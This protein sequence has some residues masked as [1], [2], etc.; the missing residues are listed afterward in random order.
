MANIVLP[1]VGG[2]VGFVLGGPAGAMIGA[3]LGSMAAGAFFSKSQRVKLPTQE[4]PRIA[5][6]R[7]QVSTYGNVI[8]RVY[9]TMRLAGNVIWSTD[10]KEVRSEHT[11]HHSTGGGKGGGGGG[12]SVSQTTVSYSYYITLAIAICEGPVDEI[13]RVWADSMVL[14]QNVL[15]ANQ[16]RYNVHLGHENQ[17]PDDIIAKYRQAGTFPAYRG[18]AYVVIEDFSL[19]GF[20]NRIPNFTFEVRRSVRFKPAPEDK[21]KE[22]VLIPGSGEFVYSTNVVTKQGGIRVA[23]KSGGETKLLP[24]G[25]KKSINMHNYQA[26][27]DVLLAV[28]QLLK[29]LPNLESIALVVTWFATSTNVGNCRIVPKVEFKD[30]N[31]IKISPEG[32]SVAGITRETAEEVLRFNKDTPTYGGTPS[33]NS[34]LEIIRELKN[35]GKQVILYP[36]IFVDEIKPEAKP[37][38]GRIIPNNTRD[39]DGWF[40]KGDGY[41]RFILHYAR[42]TKGLVDGFII[43]SELVGMTSFCDAG[44]YPAVNQL[45]KLAKNVKQIVGSSKVIYAADWS[46]YHSHEACYNLDPLW[47]SPHIDIVGIDSYFPLT[48]DLPQA[49]ITEEK[50]K[51]YW[52][53]G[54]GWDYYFAG[55]RNDENSKKSYNDPK[56][57]WK[58]LEHWWSNP[59]TN[60]DGKQTGW[61]PKM[62]PIWFTELGFPSVDGCANQPNVFYD[63]SSRE[64]FFPRASKGRIN[65]QAQ[66]EA[67]NA[68]LDY[69]QTRTKQ[70][71]KSNLVAKSFLWCWD[72]RPFPFWPD[73]DGVWQDSRLWATG[74]WLNGKLGNSTLGAIVSELLELAGLNKSD[75]DV[76]R[77]TDTVEGYIINQSI[78]I[79]GALEQLACSYFFDVVE[80]DGILKCVPRGKVNVNLDSEAK[81]LSLTEETIVPTDK[82]GIADTLEIVRAQELELPN[83][84]NVTYIDR[85]FNYDPVTQSSQRQTVKAVEQVTLN[86][87]IVMSATLAKKIA[88]VT[89]YG[90][91]KER[92]SF[93]FM[94]PPKYAGL[95]P[96]DVINVQANGFIHQ[97]RIIKTDIERNGLM[98]I[99]A[100]AEDASSYDF[101]SN[102]GYM[103]NIL[104]AEDMLANTWLELLD[105]PPLPLDQSTNQGYLRIAVAG[106]T[107]NWGGAAIYSSNDGGEKSNNNFTAVTG[108]DVS[109]CIGAAITLLNPGKFETWDKGNTVE[110]VLLSGQL[111][112]SN[113]LSVLNGANA[114]I[115]GNELIQ[116]QYAELIGEQTYRLSKLLRGRQGT[117]N[118]IHNHQEGERFVLLSPALHTT[119]MSTNMIGRKIHYKAVTAGSSIEAAEEQEFIYQANSLKPFA[120]V[121]ITGTRNEDGNLTITWIR[122]ARHDNDWRDNVDV[123]L[124]EESEKYQ[125]EILDNDV[126][127]RALETSTPTIIYSFQQQIDDFKQLQTQVTIKI[128]QLSSLV[129][130]GYPAIASI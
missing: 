57:A 28:D 75:F 31:N 123:P 37:W 2:A 5:E 83:Q 14:T 87:P 65:F 44:N 53:K 51:E 43:G 111:A 9:G 41:N 10:I 130:R 122:R 45:V 21:I 117:E 95:E 100:V 88:D 116:F 102:S 129:G 79:R 12:G 26:Q 38:R 85:P 27:A 105:L 120:P 82:N 49:Q 23:V 110:V 106:D 77:L 121:H 36:M 30:K 24:V 78:T 125:I 89:L 1:V 60:P 52:E 118:F 61:K 94:L 19:S 42:L 6:L 40:T 50:I 18:I 39:A 62:K 56:H 4:G 108:I 29:T 35:R 104:E 126:V 15:A 13:I 58:N 20:G 96:T 47:S 115:L 127:V 54:E 32:W 93:G 55:D 34:C 84:V 72:A 66:R 92:V 99:A 25:R 98:R 8:P 7:A 59:H 103:K 22:I 76:T 128:Y 46:E 114:A 16:G 107:N 74:H 101:N 112:S 124:G 90:A 119:S 113:E 3:N 91:W 11:T 63:P 67:L 71:G 48:E 69:L 73:L 97:M 80:A 33:D 70:E 17:P 81:G 86:L 109:S 64:S 68:S